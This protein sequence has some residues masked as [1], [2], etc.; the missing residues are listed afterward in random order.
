M[1]APA[2]PQSASVLNKVPLEVMLRITAYLTTPDLGRLR[3][4]CRAI[5]QSLFNIFARE[6]FTK[7]QFMLTED[8]LQAFVDMSQS[9]MSD[10]IDHVIIGLNG[11][12]EVS[13]NDNAAL[14]NAYRRAHADHITLVSSGQDIMMLTE[15]FRNLK[16]L[17][18]V[19]IRDYHSRERANRDPNSSWASY[20]A[21][22]LQRET[23]VDLLRHSSED[24]A[25]KV[26]IT[27]FT[28]L[29]MADARP[30]AF[31]LLRKR[32]CVPTDN[33][34]N[35][36]TKYLKPKVIPVL[37]SIESLVLVA[38]VNRGPSR[39]VSTPGR[40][41]IV[42]DYLLRQ[43]LGHFINLK[44]LR[45]NFYSTGISDEDDRFLTWLA[46]VPPPSTPSSA[47]V[48]P[49]GLLSNGLLAPVPFVDF[50]LK[51][52]NLGFCEMHPK[53]LMELCRK[54]APTLRSL[55]LYRVSLIYQRPDN[56]AAD[57][58][59]RGHSKVNLWAKT[60]RALRELQ[61]LNLDHVM[62]GLPSQ[63]NDYH[64]TRCGFRQLQ[65][66]SETQPPG[67]AQHK[68]KC[69]CNDCIPTV[70][71][72]KYTGIDWKGFVED[73]AVCVKLEQ[74]P[75]FADENGSDNGEHEDDDDEVDSDDEDDDLLDMLDDDLMLMAGYYPDDVMD[76]LD[77]LEDMIMMDSMGHVQDP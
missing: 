4:A 32:H 62:V 44:H 33:A 37:Q 26:V 2:D 24:Y 67:H 65:P 31:E 20:G 12:K 72:M 47:V 61:C 27:L 50:K 34:F 35:L 68:P 30:K 49:G 38:N 17:R 28:A 56:A 41:D 64:T 69:Q 58:N 21:T 76:T 48:T 6:F 11:F 1:E 52:L 57:T 66:Q 14:H 15:A 40:R 74:Q 46:S 60:L 19:G 53:R 22:T 23:G 3:L 55:E 25:N 18:T 70:S 36:F 59:Q 8:S 42:H 45:I 73:M 43:F 29:G 63:R 51:E 13:R 5:E 71:T 9:R 39:R 7:R 54:F 16:N 10:C 77:D 75:S